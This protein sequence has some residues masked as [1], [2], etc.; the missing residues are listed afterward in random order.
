MFTLKTNRYLF[1]REAHNASELG[2]QPWTRGVLI[3]VLTMVTCLVALMSQMLVG[4]LEPAVQQIGLTQIFIGV[5]LVA[6]V[7][8]AAEHSTAVMVAMKNKME[9]T[10]GIAVRSS[11]QIALL[12]APAFVFAN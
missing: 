4:V 1:T 7:G 9:L 2:Q 3:T 6:L 12:I 8:N 11:L 5:L 10:Y